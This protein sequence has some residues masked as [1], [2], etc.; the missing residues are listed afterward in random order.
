MQK[1]FILAYSLCLSQ[2]AFGQNYYEEFKQHIQAKNIAGQKS[3]LQKWE[4]VEPN[5]PELFTSY[6]NYYFFKS[7]EDGISIE[8]K[9]SGELSL[10]M[11]DSL[12]KEWFMND[13][14]W[15]DKDLLNKGFEHINKGIEKHPKRLDMRFGKCYAYNQ[16]GNWDS[17]TQE[18]IKAIDFGKS[19]D[20]QWLWTENDS[21][22]NPKE[23][24][25]GS[26]QDYVT[27]LYNT[28]NDSLLSNM[29]KISE[30]VIEYYPNEVK[31]L[32]NIA[33]TYIVLGEYEK[34]LPL[35][36]K[37]EKINPEDYIVLNNI[38]NAYKR[39]KDIENAIKYYEKMLTY[40]DE[41]AKEFAT[42][43]LEELKK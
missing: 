29:R 13:K 35:L 41:Q 1:I 34:G 32:S 27:Q 26:I 21:L 31:F 28:G 19:I 8:E 12:G 25:L 40:G 11:K 17:F 15:F 5:N 16:L 39:L 18:I 24:F 22:E 7:R 42:M 43:E 38:A 9:Q 36:L 2:L 3:V 14:V 6:F 10:T 33:I 37:A 23:F 30:K 20:N 4:K